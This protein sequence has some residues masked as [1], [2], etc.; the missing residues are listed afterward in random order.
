MTYGIHS[1]RRLFYVITYIIMKKK[2]KPIADEWVLYDSVPT[3]FDHGDITRLCKLLG[4]D[5]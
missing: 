2:Y 5:E 3:L 4:R 1:G